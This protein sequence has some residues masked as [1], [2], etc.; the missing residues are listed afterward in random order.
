VSVSLTT[1]DKRVAM[2]MEPRA[3][4][5]ADRLAAISGLTKAGV[6]VSVMTAPIVPGLTEH[7]LPALLKAAAEAG[8][9]SAGYVLLRL[10]FQVKALFMEWLERE[11]PEKAAKVEHGIRETREGGLY[12]SGWFERQRGKGVRAEQLAKTFKMFTRRYG[13]DRPMEGVSSEAFLERK[14]EREG[15]GQMGLFG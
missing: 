7:E 12:S 11:F 4:S 1:L 13:L 15:R 3:S 10:P 6:P 14:A 9:V 8:A 5:P 2:K